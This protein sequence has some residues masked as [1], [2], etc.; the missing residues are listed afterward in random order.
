MESDLSV[1]ALRVWA[2]GFTSIAIGALATVALCVALANGA[3]RVRAVLVLMCL[4]AGCALVTHGPFALLVFWE[5]GG[6]PW[7]EEI[8]LLFVPFGEALVG[9]LWLS[10]LILFEDARVTPLRLAPT[11]LL[12]AV[13]AASVLSWGSGFAF[14]FGW[15]AV[16]INSALAAHTFVCVARGWQGDLVERR[17]RMRQPL[18]LVQGLAVA[19]VVATQGVGFFSRVGGVGDAIMTPIYGAFDVALAAMAIVIGALLLEP[20]AALIAEPNPILPQ[21][22][23]RDADDTAMAKLEDLMTRDEVWRTEGLTVGALARMADTPEHRLRVLING[24]M[25]HRNF[26]AFINDRR[27]ETACRQLADPAFADA[28]ISKIAYALGFASLGPFN[29]A[30]KAATGQTPTEWRR[31]KLKTPGA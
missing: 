31:L 19:I 25:G 22:V 3:R 5:A 17:R 2:L 11:A 24:R 1:S 7:P 15:L 28:P 20:R 23:D 14:L 12:M 18:L 21:R 29:R 16:A 4:S 6:L 30:F 8:R 26:A 13:S 9:L 10:V 27:I